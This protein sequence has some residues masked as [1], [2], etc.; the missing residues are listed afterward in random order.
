MPPPSEATEW[1]KSLEDA[2]V[3]DAAYFKALASRLK[4]LVCTGDDEA[5]DILRGVLGGT[6][7][8]ASDL[9]LQRTFT[10]ERLVRSRLFALGPEAP[11]LI[12]FIMNPS[13]PVSATLTNVDRGELVA[14]KQAM[15]GNPAKQSACPL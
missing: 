12:D 4:S 2:R 6:R 11:A 1:R 13:C 14:I 8:T 15:V 10:S 5:I 9:V 3:D 7:F